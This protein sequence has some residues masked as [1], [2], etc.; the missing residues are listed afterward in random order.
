MRIEDENER[1]LD[2]LMRLM[3]DVIYARSPARPLMGAGL[4]AAAVLFEVV[5]RLRSRYFRHRRLHRSGLSCQVI[6]IGNLALGGTGKTPLCI[7]LACLI[8]EAGYRVA[9]LSRGYRGH[10][11]KTGAVVEAGSSIF[12]AASQVGDEPAL[13]AYLLRPLGIPVLVGRDR[14]ASGRRA[15]EQFR[16]DV[17]LLDDG[18]QHQR[19]SRNLDI[20]LLDG[21]KPLGNGYLLP[22]GPLREPPSA[23]ARAD[24]LVYTRCATGL[25]GRPATDEDRHLIRRIPALAT[26][27][28]LACRHRPVARGRLAV[29][30]AGREPASIFDLAMLKALPVLAFAGLARNETFR[31]TLTDLEADLR[32]WLEFSDHHRYRPEDLKRIEREGRLKGVRALVTTDK[33]RVRIHENWICTLPLL[34]VGVTIDFGDQRGLFRQH[35]CDRLDLP[36]NREQCP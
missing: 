1:S 35:I 10:A 33:D 6:S 24:M 5:V 8:R 26:K 17:I 14:L 15:L 7:Y 28:R 36:A 19:L 32:G 3:T 25:A 22:R 20:V 29:Y 18:F 27:P 12:A 16:P 2:R 9:I 30:P 4:R 23:L 34:V 13:M 11:E 21:Q 31:Q